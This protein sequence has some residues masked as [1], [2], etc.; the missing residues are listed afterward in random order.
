MTEPE[1]HVKKLRGIGLVNVLGTDEQGRTLVQCPSRGCGDTA[2][3]DADGRVVCPTGEA[4]SAY[5]ASVLAE[6]AP[7]TT[8]APALGIYPEEPQ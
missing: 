7:P 5:L 4:V 1:I 3:I 6:F 2:Y 8:D